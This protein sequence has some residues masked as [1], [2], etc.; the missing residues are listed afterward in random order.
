LSHAETK[1]QQLQEA[2]SQAKLDEEAA[3]VKNAQAV[4]KIH[5]LAKERDEARSDAEKSEKT[6]Y[7]VCSFVGT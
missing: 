4:E 3:W 6:R 1:I 2:I 7:L 5:R